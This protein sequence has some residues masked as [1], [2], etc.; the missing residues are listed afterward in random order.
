MLRQSLERAERINR[1]AGRV[2]YFPLE[3][4]LPDLP[5]FKE[6]IDLYARKCGGARVPQ[7]SAFDFKDLRGWHAQFCLTLFREDMSDGEIRILGE[8]YRGLYDGA[9]WQGMRMSQTDHL[10]LPDLVGYFSEMLRRP[11]IGYFTG[12]LPSEGREHVNV[13]ILDLPALDADGRCRYVLSFIREQSP[14]RGD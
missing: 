13:D 10:K 7:R 8:G 12:G 4:G 6:V 5:I 3:A 9:L 1:P 14:Y 11:A 2:Y